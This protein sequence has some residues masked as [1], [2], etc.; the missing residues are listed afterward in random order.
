MKIKGRKGKERKGDRKEEREVKKLLHLTKTVPKIV[1]AQNTH[2]STLLKFSVILR[3]SPEQE[4]S[5]VFSAE[6]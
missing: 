1:L 4:Y 3:K 6:A 2:M 5:T